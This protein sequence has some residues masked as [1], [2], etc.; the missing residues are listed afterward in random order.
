MRLSIS[1]RERVITIYV[2]QVLHFKKHRFHILKQLAAEQDIISSEK[3][4]ILTIVAHFYNHFQ[5]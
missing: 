5:H 4:Y 2:N 3:R 1:K